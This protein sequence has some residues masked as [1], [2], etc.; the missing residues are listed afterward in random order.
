[1][2]LRVLTWNLK[3]GRSVPPSGRELLD[4]FGAA[5]QRWDWDVALLQEVPPWWTAPLA[6]RLGAEH[7]QVLTARNALPWLR[8]ALARRWPEVMKSGG[9]GANAILARRDRIVA[10]EVQVLTLTPERRVAHGVSLGC[11][12]WVAN[13]HATAHDTGAA[14]R[15][16]ATA[17]AAALR[18]ARGAP[19]VF[20]GDFNLR[21]PRWPGFAA[22]GGHDVDHLF[23]AGAVMALGA[24][25]VLDR[26]ALSDHAPVAVD[27]RLTIG[28]D[29]DGPDV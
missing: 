16:G 23:T 4:E 12:A 13:L 10:H 15:D 20:G 18:W 5:L 28:E 8:R 9:G 2:H 29:S 7:R 24:A 25:E 27:L 22:A 1:M 26:G 11:G 6:R 14:E 3:H 21:A 17:A 19:L